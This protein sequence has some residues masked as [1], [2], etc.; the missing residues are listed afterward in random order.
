MIAASK[1]GNEAERLKALYSYH[2]L[3][4][5]YEE[6]FDQLARLAAEIC[7][8][9]IST[10]TLIDAER[11]WFK[12]VVGISEKEGARH[13]SLC[14]HTILKD[15]L[16]V[17][18]N[19]LEDERFHDNPYV[20]DEPP[21]RFYAGVP[22]ITNDGF[23]IGALCVIDKIER[24]LDDQQQRA[25]KALA[26][27]IMTQLELHRS[28]YEKNK[29][30][31]QINKQVK[32][33]QAELVAIKNKLEHELQIHK[34]DNEAIMLWQSLAETTNE[35][36]AIADCSRE[37]YP[38]V[39]VNDGF[40][41]MSGY[42]AEEIIDRNCRFLQ[43]PDTDQATVIKIRQ[44]IKNEHA[45]TCEILNYKKNGD[46][47]W[48]LLQLRP[49]RSAGLE[50]THI[51][52]TQTDI[53]ARKLEQ[54]ET[55]NRTRQL[56]LNKE[57][58]LKLAKSK[59][60]T[61]EAAYCSLLETTATT[62]SIA[63]VSIWTYNQD[64]TALLCQGS[65][66]A[67]EYYDD[68]D[69]QLNVDDY[70]DYFNALKETSSMLV[71]DVVK[72]RRTCEL[73]ENYSIPLGISSMMD[74]PI[75][76]GGEDIG[77]LC[78]EHTGPKRAWSEEDESFAIT[79]GEMCA[80]AIEEE[81][82]RWVE[83]SLRQSEMSLNKAQQLAHL[84]NWIW[85]IESGKE[86][87]SE[88]QFHIYGVRPGEFQPTY[89]YFL[90][91]VHPDDKEKVI[92][93]I[94]AALKG[95]QDYDC[96]H[97]IINPDGRVRHVHAHAE[98]QRDAK[99]L[100]K[101]MVG[102][103]LEV[104]QWKETELK[105]NRSNR[106]L[107]VL[108]R[109]NHAVIHLF[110]ESMLLEKVCEILVQEGGYQ[111]AWIGYANS[112]EDKTISIMSSFG[113]EDAY[114]D[115]VSISWADDPYGQG[116]VGSAIQTNKP[117]IIRDV[118]KDAAFLPW[119][120]AASQR[121]YRSVIGLPLRLNEKD[122]GV[123]T[124]YA[125]EINA[126]DDE[127]VELL[128]NLAANMNH[129]IITLRSGK[130]RNEIE[131]SLQKNHRI[132][133]MLNQCNQ[134]VL[135]TTDEKNLLN[136]ICRIIVEAGGYCM[137]G[138]GFK[139]A[140]EKKSVNMVAY[141]GNN[142]NY[143]EQANVSWDESNE[144]GNGPVGIAIRS[145]KSYVTQ[146]IR[147]DSAFG[148]WRQA[149]LE[150]G[151]AAG[152]VLPLIYNGRVLGILLVYSKQINRFD[153]EE[154]SLLKSL[155]DN[156][157]LGIGTLRMDQKRKRVEEDLRFSEEKFSKIFRNSPYAVLISTVED[158]KIVDLNNN[159]ENI[160]GYKRDEILGR[161]S[162]DFGAWV[163]PADREQVVHE[164][165]RHGIIKNREVDMQLRSG[166]IRKIEMSAE[167]INIAGEAYMISV[168]KDVTERRTLEQHLRLQE[169]IVS[170]NN[171][172]LSFIDSHY[173]YQAANDAFLKNF[174]L[175]SEEVVGKHIS[176]VVGERIFKDTIK[177]NLDRCLSGKHIVF[178]FRIKTDD[179]NSRL[180]DVHYSPF[181]EQDGSISGVVVSARDI[182]ERE[183]NEAVI[184]TSR[185]R[186]RGLVNRLNKVREEE[187]TIMSRDIHDELGQRLTGLK[188]DL[189]WIKSHVP[190]HWKKI[191]ERLDAV[192]SLTDSTLD[193]TRNMA[194]QLRPVMLDD[195]GLDAAIENEAQNFATRV[196]FECICK[197]E[198]IKIDNKDMAIA[199]FR[200]AQESLTN[201][202][203]HSNATRVEIGMLIKNSSLNLTVSDNGIGITDA[204]IK[205]TNSLGVIGMR[206]RAGVFGGR[207]NFYQN[208]GG[209]TRMEMKIP[210]V[211]NSQ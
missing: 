27:Q 144:F 200:I 45:I 131:Q 125:K 211:I 128:A 177:N 40:K 129:G 158:G 170:S 112:D 14:A 163:N 182:T 37:D 132:L 124:I 39:Y 70:P 118:L 47:F 135:N 28:L 134:T 180:F 143:L 22:L 21:I 191:P 43:G 203:R 96:E 26:E 184:K 172:M 197:L 207:V 12:S 113:H 76:S 162:L 133:A 185:E 85:D 89:E 82:K 164:L 58:L 24:T 71:N 190:K 88:E 114:L 206:E 130:E 86:Q 108:S 99:G 49:I 160:S 4:T 69:L 48:N 192:M 169:Y 150:R 198:N 16:L 142:S 87:W 175:S 17:V 32:E 23:N 104:S 90:E 188:M 77:V 7:N 66:H 18:N 34:W 41:R 54:E 183:R 187:R 46:P 155:A 15:A 103:V 101:K 20:L 165:N 106:A 95:E 38:I 78:H 115:S 30:L 110:E 137:S 138:V 84:G 181:P 5:A 31:Q 117:F 44:A 13:I 67:G 102:T 205:N 10:I 92:N 194:L 178:D 121:G 83:D 171:D 1:P 166:E 6:S 199:I 149:A 153:N 127:E 111:F 33:K 64:H 148:P 145:R 100:A 97:R 168:A 122:K 161:S 80:I 151:Y 51:I 94:N 201:I 120:Q 56:L 193:Y 126:F 52:A 176:D 119:R 109:C 123:L 60:S 57:A 152:I 50:I 72:D 196:G 147:N 167:T 8:T 195:L 156:L 75:R 62:L 107:K 81:E 35:G 3:D 36:F 186:L 61:L 202:A 9:P 98:V 65:Y 2:V 29:A 74:I 189:F 59:H 174:H 139:L 173:I 19:T 73:V 53:T 91:L 208:D 68:K 93:T 209:G 204:I 146:D 140:D 179:F 116:P 79:I 63:R 11:E 105:V 154:I 55:I 42:Q 210:L 159:A 141:Y 25:L 136:N 157:A